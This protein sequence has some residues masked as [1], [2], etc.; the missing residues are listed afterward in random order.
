LNGFD[1][2]FLNQVNT[3]LY[4]YADIFL[5]KNRTVPSKPCYDYDSNYIYFGNYGSA[6]ATKIKAYDES[7]SFKVVNGIG[8]KWISFPR[9]ERYKDEIFDAKTLL[10]RIKPWDQQTPEI[11]YMEYKPTGADLTISFDVNSGWQLDPSLVNLKSTQGY[12]LKYQGETNLASIRLEGAKEDYDATIDL[13]AG[14]NWVGYFLD[15]SYKPQECLPQDIWEG[16]IQIQTQYWTLT[17]LP[18]DPP[19]WKYLGKPGP[20]HYGDLVVLVTNHPY[21]DFQ[22]HTPSGGG[23]AANE[24]PETNYFTF[25][26]KADYLPFYVETDSLSDIVEIAI[27]ADG[28][29]K[30]AAVRLP[31][32]TITEVNG[33]LEGVATGAVIEFQTWNSYKSEPVEK[34]GYVV[35]DHQRQVREKRTIY[36]GEK[37]RYYHVSLKSNEVYDLP[38]DIGT[39][40]CKPNPFRQNVD[41]SFRLNRE[42]NIRIEI[43]DMQGNRIK[44]VIN[45][46]YPEGL[47]NFTWQGDN[48]AGNR[49]TPGIYFYKVST[50][51]EVVQTDKIVMIK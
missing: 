15:E 16:L 29:V 38:P 20:F 51:S 37:A 18:S 50:W 7:L 2:E 46:N 9:M 36:T 31:G 30:G 19:V 48:E 49:I 12:K 13:V 40:T 28:E 1:N 27:L 22:W 25:E 6:T 33:Y 5:S 17:K 26:E 4:T 24:I 47:Y 42:G 8:W 23:G 34:D 45:G 11:L 3:N 39:V 14:E 44:T 21:Q 43:F 10:S 32:D 35:I 41:F